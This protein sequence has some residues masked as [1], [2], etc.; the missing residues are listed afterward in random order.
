MIEFDSNLYP[1]SNVKNIKIDKD[2]LMLTIYFLD[3]LKLYPKSITFNSIDELN[4]KVDEL[5]GTKKRTLFG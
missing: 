3:G 4:K 2:N 1:L 5:N